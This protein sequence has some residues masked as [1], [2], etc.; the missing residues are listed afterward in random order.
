MAISQVFTMDFDDIEKD[1]QTYVNLLNTLANQGNKVAVMFV[2]D[3]I[4]NGSYVIYNDSAKDIIAESFDLEDIKQGIYID[5][6]VSRKKQMVPN[7]M[8]RLMT[9]YN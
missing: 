2:T 1:M 6:L 7:I 5:N 3:V 4:K 8:E 9:R